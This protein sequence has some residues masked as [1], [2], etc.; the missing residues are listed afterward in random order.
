[1]LTG[2]LDDLEPKV[3]SAEINI[4]AELLCNDQN[5]TDVLA[6][7]L[8][9]QAATLSG[10]ANAR[11]VYSTSGDLY[12]VNGSGT[13]VRITNGATLDAAGLGGFTGDY[14]QPAVDA[15][16]RYTDSAKLYDFLT[17]D[18]PDDKFANVAVGDLRIF[19]P[20]PATGSNRVQIAVPA[21]LAG[22]YDLELPDDLPAANRILTLDNLGK[23]SHTDNDTLN[24]QVDDLEV[25]A[26]AGG[27]TVEGNGGIT[28]NGSTGLLVNSGATEFNQFTVSTYSPGLRLGGGAQAGLD[29]EVGHYIRINNW[30]WF[31]ARVRKNAVSIANL[32]I[33][34]DVPVAMSGTLD[35]P[36]T[37]HGFFLGN[38]D[39]VISGGAGVYPIPEPLLDTWS[40]PDFNLSA[41]IDASDDRVK[42][43]VKHDLDFFDSAGSSNFDRGTFR[44]SAP[45]DVMLAV[46][47]W[48]KID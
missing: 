20:D 13:N 2:I 46:S 9:A 4:D 14:G 25:K 26:G 1:V 11:K 47:G 45:G 3:K 37:V 48:Y 5:L 42:L 24:A 15:V 10:A 17:D 43:A 34:C 31:Y 33:G 22:N 32:S 39:Q 35:F 30:V 6:A 41:F 28:I 8:T 29:H 23:V 12:F 16:A 40:S 18:T 36:V 19:E 7:Q 27:I 44:N 21:G 38:W